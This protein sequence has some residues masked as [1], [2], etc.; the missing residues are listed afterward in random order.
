[1]HHRPGLSESVAI[2]PMSLSDRYARLVYEALLED[3]EGYRDM[4]ALECTACGRYAS[5]G[6]CQHF[7]HY[8]FTVHDVCVCV[9]TDTPQQRLFAEG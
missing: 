6:G 5:F 1:M 7:L 4:P 8:E 3:G 9:S 2:I